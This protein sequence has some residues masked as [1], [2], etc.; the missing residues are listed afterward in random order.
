[1]AGALLALASSGTSP[2]AS[3]ATSGP[4]IDDPTPGQDAFV[5]ERVSE[6]VS[7]HYLFPETAGEI[8]AYVKRR[9]QDGA[10]SGR[11][12]MREFTEL[13][14]ADLQ[15]ISGDRHL[16][17]VLGRDVAVTEERMRERRRRLAETNHGFNEVDRLP[18]NVGYLEI[19]EF[20]PLD[21]AGEAMRQAFASLAGSDAVI[22]DL[23]GN[24][25]GSGDLVPLICGHFLGART[26]LYD[27]VDPRTDQAE[28]VSTPK[29]A[30]PLRMGEIPLYVLTD[31]ETY[32]AAECLAYTLQSLAAAVVVG[33]RTAGGAHPTRSFVIR[34][35]E[36]VVT[37]PVRNMINPRTGTNW[38][39][40]GVKPDLEVPAGLALETALEHY[41]RQVT[42]AQ[43]PN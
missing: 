42:T 6:I 26:H 29:E 19:T 27:I 24:K 39:G 3:G 43:R 22:L 28:K 2:R 25:G 20:C 15:S 21:S 10:Y 17:V 5:V 9:W 30:D 31:G 8:A 13:L 7:D 32:S 41:R 1:V 16:S 33:E 37:V 34:E 38:E 18:G 36:I 40:A 4:A 35:A 12:S 23:R 14:T 11:D